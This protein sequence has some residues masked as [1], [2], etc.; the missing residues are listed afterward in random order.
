MSSTA[1]ARPTLLQRIGNL[2]AARVSRWVRKR[3]GQET[4]PVTL[5]AKRLYILPTLTGITYGIV[6]VAMLLG[7]MNYNNSMGFALTFLLAATGLVAMHRCHQN[8]SGVNVE[9]ASAGHAFAGDPMTFTVVLSETGQRTKYDIRASLD[10]SVSH[11]HDI[12]P[13][14]ATSLS[15]AIPTIKRGILSLPRIGLSTRFPLSLL[16]CWVWIYA[17]QKALVWPRPAS[18]APVRPKTHTDQSGADKG[19]GEEDFAGLRDYQRG[20]SSRRVAWKAFARTGDMKTRMFDGG[21]LSTTWI[22]LAATSAADIE[23]RLEVLCRWIIDAHD[24]GE[25]Y[26]L[27][28]GDTIVEPAEGLAHRNACLD[29]LAVFGESSA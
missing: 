7:S 19:R 15:V 9:Q 17:D 5:R 21:S 22:D 1:S 14:L 13:G 26:G 18:D 3:Q 11:A 16:R 25:R 24:A 2:G 10:G 6:V 23:T 12:E 4:L 28:L 8:L 20:D 27:R 29:A